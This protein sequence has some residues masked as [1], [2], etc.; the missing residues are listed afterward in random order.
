MLQIEE[1]IASFRSKCEEL[2]LTYALSI[3]VSKELYVSNLFLGGSVRLYYKKK[4]RC[5]GL[6][7]FQNYTL[8]LVISNAGSETKEEQCYLFYCVHR[9]MAFGKLRQNSC[10]K[11]YIKFA[12][13]E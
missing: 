6:I 9:K 1:K 10:T 4:I 7:L 8:P 5:S 13:C 2:Q 12:C 11:Q 3:Q